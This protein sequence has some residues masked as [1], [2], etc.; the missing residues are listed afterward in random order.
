MSQSGG[1]SQSERL[2][3]PARNVLGTAR[4]PGDKSI[5]HRYAMLGGIARGR[6][7]IRNFSAAADCRSTLGCLRAMGVASQLESLPEGDRVVIDGRGLRGLS[8]PAECLDAG[9]SGSTMRMIAGILAGQS[10]SCSIAGDSSL[11][12][13]P[14]LRI[15]EPL[16]LMGAKIEAAEGKHAPLKIEGGPLQAISYRTPM[17][18][19]Q[20]KSAVLLAGLYAS[21]TTVVEE[22]VRTR[23][24]TEIALADFGARVTRHGRAC[25]VEGGVE[26]R[27]QSLTVPGDLSSAAFFLVAA[28]LFPESNLTIANVGLN[29]T[30]AELLD[31]LR[32]IGAAVSISNMESAG[33]EIIGDLHANGGGE[34][35]PVVIDQASAPGLIDEIPVLAVLGAASGRG[36]R[37]SGAGELRVKESDR[38][39]AVTA[40]LRSMGAEVTEQ[41]DG[42]IV[43]SGR[44]LHGARID[45][46]GDHRIAMAF[47]IAALRAEGET[48]IEDPG[49]AEVSFPGFYDV[50][51]SIV[52]R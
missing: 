26:L 50:L 2:V 6:T 46:R 29:P 14:M 51:E 20:V 9:N 25:E 3:L 28:L 31:F 8:A 23:D 16:R 5:S 47:S 36:A 19:A 30:R 40:N 49:C 42:L 52:E 4:V 33:G 35:G 48:L 10:F 39:A 32:G 22:A 38:I 11:N 21:G 15:I 24:H 1:M 41:P 45:T 7:E 43:E 12:Q 37:I 17:P 34:L 18:S 13:R 44:P 27:G